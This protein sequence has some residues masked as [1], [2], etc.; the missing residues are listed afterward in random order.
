M[1]SAFSTLACSDESWTIE[2]DKVASLQ[3]HIDYYLSLQSPYVMLVFKLRNRNILWETSQQTGN[4]AGREAVTQTDRYDG[5]QA[6]Q[7]TTSLSGKWKGNEMDKEAGGSPNKESDS[8]EVKVTGRAQA[9]SQAA[10][11]ADQR[12]DRWAQS[13]QQN[14]PKVHQ[15][16]RQTHKCCCVKPSGLSCTPGEV[17]STSDVVPSRWGVSLQGASDPP[18]RWSVSINFNAAKISAAGSW[19]PWRSSARRLQRLLRQ[20]DSSDVSVWSLDIQIYVWFCFRA[21]ERKKKTHWSNIA[22]GIETFWTPPARKCFSFCLY[23]VAACF[24]IC[25]TAITARGNYLHDHNDNIYVLFSHKK[26]APFL[27]LLKKSRYFS[28]KI[29]KSLK[30]WASYMEQRGPRLAL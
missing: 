27:T 9:G 18:L 3:T 16:S 10:M 6:G 22:T 19:A 17:V 14:K 29:C 7:N 28:V 12:G 24:N 20:P 21:P 25:D 30:R 26:K 11:Q 8:W 23:A 1:H 4:E 13:Q 5:R 2:T 15:S